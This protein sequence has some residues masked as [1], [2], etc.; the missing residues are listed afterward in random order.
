MTV[1]VI[2]T[3]YVSGVVNDDL[4]FSYGSGVDPT[5]GCAV[6]LH[7]RMFYL[8]GWGDVKRQV[9]FE[10]ILLMQIIYSSEKQNYWMRND[11]T[12]RFTVQFE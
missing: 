6:T 9:R 5:Y 1:N 12:K 7:G 11:Q 10:A 3:I 2:I 4:D 8:G